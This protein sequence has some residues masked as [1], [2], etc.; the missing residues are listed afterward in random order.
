MYAVE[1]AFQDHEPVPKTL[2]GLLRSEP[3]T[4]IQSIQSFFNPKAHFFTLSHP[5]PPDA[6]IVP[7]P[8]KDSHY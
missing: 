7:I 1:P 6:C 2:R 4:H 8:H 5:I 3:I